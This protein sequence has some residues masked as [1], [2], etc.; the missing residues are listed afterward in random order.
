MPAESTSYNSKWFSQLTE[1]QFANLAIAF[2]FIIYI[3]GLVGIL[4]PIHADFI[5]LTP[6]NLLISLGIVLSFHKEWNSKLYAF[7]AIAFLI[8]LGIE[9]LGVNTGLVFGEY[10]YGR[11]LGWKIADTPFMI[12][13]NWIML[14]YC[15][16]VTIHYILEQQNWFIKSILGA[17]VMVLLDILIEPV[18]MA[19]DFW[20]WTDNIVPLQNYI[21]WYI[22]S[23]VL[24]VCF[25][26]LGNAM[27][28]KV[29]VALLILQFLFFGIL[30]LNL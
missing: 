11:V 30:N 2:L 26:K 23:F 24:L 17:G 20:N 6:V 29:A 12:G 25:Y 13:V 14:V 5:L 27:K 15:S 22:I 28:N 19:Y 4:L 10:D 18:A 9:I 7:I 8:G 21:A 1:G 3:V 16:G